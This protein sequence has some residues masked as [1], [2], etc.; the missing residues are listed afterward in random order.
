VCACACASVCVCVCVCVCVR[1]RVRACV[2]LCVCSVR[3]NGELPKFAVHILIGDTPQPLDA[4]GQ[5]HSQTKDSNQHINLRANSVC[6]FRALCRSS[7]VDLHVHFHVFNLTCDAVQH[8]SVSQFPCARTCDA[9][10]GLS[11]SQFPVV[12]TLF[13]EGWYFTL[14]MVRPAQ[15]E[16]ARP[17]TGATSLF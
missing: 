6:C 14:K 1:A 17:L 4:R 16:D 5:P 2:L 12:F 11:V 10:Q 8:L 7:H 9:V 13:T 3:F 15:T